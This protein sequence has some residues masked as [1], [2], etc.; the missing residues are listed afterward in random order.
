MEGEYVTRE[1]L[2]TSLESLRS[3]GMNTH[4]N[5]KDA[6][7]KLDGA[8]PAA[9]R[10]RPVVLGPDGRISSSL[11]PRNFDYSPGIYANGQSLSLVGTDHVYLAF[12]PDGTAAGRKAFFGFGGAADNNLSIYNEI[13]G[14]NVDMRATGAGSVNLYSNGVLT[15]EANDGRV[16]VRNSTAS[17]GAAAIGTTYLELGE[18]QT[19]NQ[20]AIIDLHASPSVDY[21]TR[22]LRYAGANGALLV[23]QDGTGAIQVFT[24]GNAPIEFYT[25]GYLRGLVKGDG[26]I[27]VKNQL[28]LGADFTYAAIRS[29]PQ[30][31][32]VANNGVAS[33]PSFM[34]LL[35]VIDVSTGVQAM[36]FTT[37][38]GNSVL[39][40]ID[41]WGYF[42]TAAGTAGKTNLYYSG[43]YKLENKLGYSASYKLVW[44]AH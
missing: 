16:W 43:G 36:F 10:S 3:W 9:N 31:L 39:E 38:A 18:G 14:A 34:G 24:S 6:A 23:R 26:D 37:G 33:L 11:M 25:Q 20:N 8:T 42:T 5:M 40:I 22:I 44:I 32:V 15:L 19:A 2:R 1:E 7:Y 30:Y 29:S 4:L 41:P 35:L 27:E 17:T 28:I 21:S 13:S 12:Y